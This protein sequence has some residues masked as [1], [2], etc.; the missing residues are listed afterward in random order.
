ME[1]DI[2]IVDQ[3]Q[4]KK[5]NLKNQ[6]INANT[7]EISA[8]SSSSEEEDDDSVSEKNH[9]PFRFNLE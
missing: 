4:I 3:N 6:N 8:E 9:G 7:S 5:N 2:Q 1:M